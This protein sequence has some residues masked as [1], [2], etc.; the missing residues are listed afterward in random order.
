MLNTYTSNHFIGF[1]SNYEDA[2]IV[3]VGAPFDGTTSY[4]PGTRFAPNQIRLDS[5]GL[6]TYSPYLDG[7]LEDLSLTDIGDIEFPF[8]NTIKVLEAIYN[9]AHT[10]VQDDKKP[11][12]IGGEHLI[13]L[14]VIQALYEKYPDLHIIHL[15]AHTDLRNEYMGEALSHAT[16]LRRTWDLVGDGRIFQFGIRSGTKAEFEWAKKHTYLEP[17]EVSTIADIVKQLAYKPIYLTIDLDVLDPSIFSGTG[18]PEPGGISMKELLLA[19]TSMQS[20]NLVGADVVEL[21]PAY[22]TSG[23]S[24]AVAC[25]VI[26][27]VALLLGHNL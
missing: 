6:E 27:E 16:V 11:L 19:L 2:S 7:D 10:L 18:T 9:C 17:F 4:R 1:N 5:Y 8:G 15:D 25:K 14:P 3:M 21:S 20:L 23:V 13:S 12:V 26:R 24:T 22:D